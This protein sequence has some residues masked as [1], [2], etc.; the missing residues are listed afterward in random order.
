VRG[1]E[2]IGSYRKKTFT[3]SKAQEAVKLVNRKIEVL[4]ML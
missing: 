3:N 4:G 1:I 2:W